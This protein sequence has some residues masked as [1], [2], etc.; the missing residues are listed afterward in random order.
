VHGAACTDAPPAFALRPHACRPNR[1]GRRERVA[2]SP[3]VD[4]SAPS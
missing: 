2:R 3:G 1:P 4:S